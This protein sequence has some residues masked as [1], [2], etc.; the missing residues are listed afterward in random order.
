MTDR[1]AP[2]V[3][4]IFNRPDVTART[5]EAI[6]KARPPKVFVFA[7]G[8]RPDRP[9]EA[10]KCAATRAV[11]D[12]IDWPC[13]VA[14]KYSD[15]NLGCGL[16]VTSAI[17]WVFDHADRA[18]IFEDDC[19]AHPSFFPYCNELLERYH[20]DE[21][22]M[23][24]AGTNLQCGHKRGTGSYFFSRFNT[25]WGWATWRRAWRHMDLSVKS[26]PAF[27]NTSW[28]LDR[29]GD[30]PATEYLARKIEDAYRAGG[31][32]DYF[33]YPWQFA[34]WQQDGL[35]IMPN[36]NMITNIG[37]QQDATHTIWGGSKW[38]NLP[39]VEMPFPLQ[40]PPNIAPDQE[41]DDFFVREV[42]VNDIPRP[43]TMLASALTMTRKAYA[44]A[45]PKSARMF[46]RTLRYRS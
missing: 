17:D 44:T 40:H 2:A 26:W 35:C 37:F 7:D 1:R 19:V 20:D 46:L 28:V 18:I 21:R 36:L 39:Q 34:T 14:K 12:R 23:Q 31:T 27:R 22:V 25:C 9:D 4:I 29:V 41:A 32:I 42:V 45:I 15:V 5:A 43:E 38:A 24:I 8:P 16:G 30:V 11:I 6:A 3:L 33:D 13:E 10:G